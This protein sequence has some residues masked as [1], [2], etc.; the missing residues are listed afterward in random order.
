[1]SSYAHIP[2]IPPLI[3]QVRVYYVGAGRK[4]REACRTGRNDWVDGN[5]FNGNQWELAEGG[6]L[7]ANVAFGQLKVYY[8]DKAAGRGKTSVAYVNLGNRNWSRRLN[9]N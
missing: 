3:L 6:G 4:L 1:M 8:K 2:L 9:M 5:A 7:S